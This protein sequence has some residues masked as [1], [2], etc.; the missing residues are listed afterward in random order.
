MSRRRVIGVEVTMDDAAIVAG[1]R[2]GDPEAL[3]VAF[4]RFRRPIRSYAARGA[5]S[6]AV[7][8]EV[9]QETFLRLA[10][11][12]RDLRPDTRL[13]A[14]LF[15]VA[16]NLVRSHRRW[17]WLDGDRLAALARRTVGRPTRPD[18]M[19]EAADAL[20]RMADALDAMPASE[21]E[22]AWLSVVDGLEPADAAAVLGVTPEAARQRLSRAR[23]RW[24]D[25][26]KEDA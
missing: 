23:A 11:H 20:N 15:T 26:L 17:A 16:R 25:A 12:G 24:R 2:A 13:A 10:R 14:W 6:L 18:E 19:V 7:A 8:D 5:G 21:R 1:L 22:V 9:V 3:R 4:D